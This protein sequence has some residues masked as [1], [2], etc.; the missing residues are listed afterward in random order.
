MVEILRWWLTG[1]LT[2]ARLSCSGMCP[3]YWAVYSFLQSEWI[4]LRFLVANFKQNKQDANAD[5]VFVCR[6]AAP[7]ASKLTGTTSRTSL[8]FIITT[9]GIFHVHYVRG[10]SVTLNCGE[11]YGIKWTLL[12]IEHWSSGCV[13]EACVPDTR[14]SHIFAWYLRIS[15]DISTL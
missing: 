15:P 13:G 12:L 7:G 14:S 5:A 4:A 1:L 8:Q 10:I 9:Y 2:A 3:I 11:N 6:T